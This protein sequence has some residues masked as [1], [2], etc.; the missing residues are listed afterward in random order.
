MPFEIHISVSRLNHVINPKFLKRVRKHVVLI[1]LNMLFSVTHDEDS[2]S[3]TF[4]LHV[5]S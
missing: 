1:T 2:R 4:G 5:Q 3:L